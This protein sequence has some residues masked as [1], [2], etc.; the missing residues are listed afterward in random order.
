MYL[1]VL[2]LVHLPL[3]TTVV[4]EQ[5]YPPRLAPKGYL[6]RVKQRNRVLKMVERVHDQKTPDITCILTDFVE[7]KSGASHPLYQFTRVVLNSY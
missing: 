6:P 1:S 5:M 2:N 7:G 4:M 3:Q